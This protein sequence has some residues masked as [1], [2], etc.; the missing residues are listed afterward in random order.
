MPS[1]PLLVGLTGG[2]GSGK[3]LAAEYFEKLGCHIINA[4]NLAKTLYK[5]DDVK[6]KLIKEFGNGILNFEGSIS[7]LKAREIFFKN[8]KNVLRVNKIVHPFVIREI[9]DKVKK[10]KSGIIIIESAIIFETGYNKEVDYTIMVYT[11]KYTR[12]KRLK[13]R[14]NISKEMFE[15]IFKIQLPEKFKKAI[16]DFVIMNNSSKAE[17]KKNIKLIYK[18][19]KIL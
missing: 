6:N 5:N 3:T 13:E 15:S 10:L 18:I 19:L 12:Y 14:D 4:D 16:A 11:S 17:F 1:K 9:N 7:L 8:R 2:I